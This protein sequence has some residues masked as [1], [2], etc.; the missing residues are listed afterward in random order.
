MMIK[1]GMVSASFRKKTVDQ[2]IDLAKKARLDS[3]EWGGDVHVPHG[4][5]QIAKQVGEKTREEGLMTPSYGSYYYAGASDISFESV[6]DTAK[7]LGAQNI[8]VWAGRK[9]SKEADSDYKNRVYEDLRRIVLLAKEQGLTVSTEYHQGTLTDIKES[10]EK[11]LSSVEGL[12]TYWQ[13]LDGRTVTEEMQILKDLG[14][15]LTNIH[16]H[17]RENNEYRP[18]L[19]GYTYWQ[20][21][22]QYFASLTG[23]RFLFL[24]IIGDHDQ[25]Q[26][27]KDAATLKQLL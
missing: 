24:E 9:G 8:R 22:I 20:E 16:V 6:L 12:Y 27:I 21:Y 10:A 5:L 26:F 7:T 13:P 17:Y 14:T 23:E 19:E 18:L 3:I 11:M 2:I 15:R 4:N 25:E 1:T